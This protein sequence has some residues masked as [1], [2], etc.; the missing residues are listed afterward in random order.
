M[1]VQMAFVNPKV[2]YSLI[3]KT[4]C[5]FGCVYHMIQIN[6]IYS[7]YAT[8]T[9]IK[10]LG[11]NEFNQPSVTLCYHKLDQVKDEFIKSYYQVRNIGD[12]VEFLNKLSIG[13]QY[14]YYGKLS[15]MHKLL[16]NS[17]TI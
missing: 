9:Y 4:L 7:S 2:I 15:K 6:R 1:L 12:Q 3:S 10:Y 17:M 16:Y 5:L 11:D 14:E 13:Q 8:T